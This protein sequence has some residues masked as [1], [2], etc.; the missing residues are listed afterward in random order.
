[1]LISFGLKPGDVFS[2]DKCPF[3]AKS[4]DPPKKR[5]FILLGYLTIE[6]KIFVITTT[7]RFEHYG[8][9]NPR[10]NHNYCKLP[11]G[12]GGLIRDSIVDFSQ[13]FQQIHING[14][15]QGKTDI[16]KTGTLK[17]EAIN[18]VVNCLEKEDRVSKIIKKRVYECLRDAGF[19]INK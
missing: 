9:G 6:G 18:T 14:F 4:D 8:P 1:M 12:A 19:K 10:Q 11:A 5:W 16:V 3:R 2:W 7:T 17:Q 15:E 13:D